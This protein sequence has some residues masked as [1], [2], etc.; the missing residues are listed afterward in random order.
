M[1]NPQLSVKIGNLKLKNPLI[2]ASGTFGYAEEFKH[3]VDLRKI[4]AII[5]KTIT[6]SPR[7]GN[8]PP[9]TVETPSGMLNSIGLENPG[10]EIFLKEK[11]PFLKRIKSP[12]IVS[13]MAEGIDEFKELAKIL[14]K[15]KGITAIELNLSCPN[16][17][18]S[19]NNVK[20]TAQD[21]KATYEA[22]E[23]VRSQTNKTLIAK[24][25]PN[26]TDITEIARVALSAGA[27]ALSLVN[28]FFAMA[29]DIETKSSVLGSVTGGLSGPAIKPMALY[30]VWQ[31]YKEIKSP[32]IG[33]G[34]IMTAQ[35]AIEFMLAGATA[36]TV[37]TANFI[38]PR[39]SIEIIESL[40]AY[41]IKNKI[42]DIR[43]LIGA[44]KYETKN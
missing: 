14:D 13:I 30:M 6:L 15:T 22:V 40:K 7:K 23:A 4:G 31:L 38:N 29:I 18:H 17:R 2:A 5:T 24:L 11:L 37:G 1:K 8:P 36:V 16:V 20:L 41:L 12:I 34:G 27:D 21:P 39:V 44:L 35:D 28:T 25:S 32:I 9:R 26:V 42:K 3:L 10:I 33:G 43:T 19:T